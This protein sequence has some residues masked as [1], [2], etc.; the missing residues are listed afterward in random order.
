M[1]SILELSEN[2]ELQGDHHAFNLAVWEG[3]LADSYL[4][5]LP[6]KIETNAHG[7]VLMSPPPRPE[8]GQEQFTI[9]FQ[10]NRA[11]PEGKIITEC[12]VSTSDGVKGVDVAWMSMERLKARRNKSAY[13]TAPEICVEVISPSN[14]RQEMDHKKSLYFEAGALEVWFCSPEGTMSF[15]LKDAPDTPAQSE[16]VPDMLL[17]IE[18]I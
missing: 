17:E 1:P 6:G 3:V 8:H 15:Y 4:A 7:Q 11:L 2:S 12:P 18:T 5:D 14:S 16:M 13:T 9:G 10:L